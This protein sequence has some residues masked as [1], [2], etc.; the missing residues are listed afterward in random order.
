MAP[1]LEFTY[2]GCRSFGRNIIRRSMQAISRHHQ[3]VPKI[4]EHY[5]V[6]NV[7]LAYLFRLTLHPMLIMKNLSH[8]CQRS[9]I[10]K[11]LSHLLS[12]FDWTLC[13]THVTV[14]WLGPQC[15]GRPARTLSTSSRSSSSCNSNTSSSSTSQSALQVVALDTPDWRTAWVLAARRATQQE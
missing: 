12:R 8:L 15:S 14:L 13:S 5:N 11:N 10:M 1:G 2:Q 4:M 3:K 7:N 9:G 6:N